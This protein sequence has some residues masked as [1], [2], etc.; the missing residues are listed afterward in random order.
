MPLP[1]SLMDPRLKAFGARLREL[2]NQLGISQY[3]L[4]AKSGCSQAEISKWERGMRMVSAFDLR[5]LAQALGVPAESLFE[6]PATTAEPE[7]PRRGRT[8]TGDQA[9]RTA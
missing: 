2:R 3:D 9:E 6:P 1:G 8:R 7:P 5:A 4:A